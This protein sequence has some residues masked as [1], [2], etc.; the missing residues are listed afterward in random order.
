MKAKGVFI[1]AILIADAFLVSY[2][3]GFNSRHVLVV[4][5]SMKAVA[6]PA[7]VKSDAKKP[8]VEALPVKKMETT[9]PKVKGKT[10]KK[11]AGHKKHAATKKT[12][13]D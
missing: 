11:S 10:H 6:P 1:S 4:D 7:D 5:P 2:A 3:I 9:K 8:P 12:G 13:N